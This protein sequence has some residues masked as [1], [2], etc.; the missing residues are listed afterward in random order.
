MNK[1][2]ADLARDGEPCIDE[3]VTMLGAFFEMLNEL[4]DTPQDPQWHA[5]GNVY[6]HTGMVLDALYTVLRGDASHIRGERRQA[7]ILAALLHDIAKP[8]QTKETEINGTMRIVSPRHEEAGRSYLAFKF[9]DLPLPFSVVWTVLGLVG[10]HH[11]PKRL[12]IKNASRG[13][14]LSLSRRVDTELLFWLEVADMKGR[15]CPD[16]SLQ[17]QYLDEF[18]MFAQEYGVWG[19]M[20]FPK[21]LEALLDTESEKARRYIQ[22]QAIA[23]MQNDTIVQEEEAIARSFSHKDNYAHLVLLCGPS[24]SGKSTYVSRHLSDYV[25]ISLDE[26]RAEV[27]GNRSN[28]KSAGQVMSLAKERLKVC[29]RNKQNVVWD[30][31]NVREDFRKIIADFGRDYNAL[32][33]LVVF[34]NSEKTLLANNATRS[35]P[36]PV[37][38]LQKQIYT[39]Q[40]PLVH[41][42]HEYIVVGEKGR[43]MMDLSS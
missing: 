18:Q 27:N 42:A 11:M 21:S 12:V 14:Y 43:I 5:E 17:L 20:Y 30:A 23:Q 16:K 34:L 15:I 4:Q 26:I 2:L 19:E 6:I 8:G 7:L 24:G 29:L 10:E 35:F 36:V 3:C 28:Q 40:F 32:I 9:M 31:T 13:E 1:W 22:V 25:V 37:D 41:E 38:V 33:T 39:Y